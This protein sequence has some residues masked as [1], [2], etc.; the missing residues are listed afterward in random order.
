[1][2]DEYYQLHQKRTGAKPTITAATGKAFKELLKVHGREIVLKKLKAF[3]ASR[4]WFAE[5]PDAMSFRR[6][7]DKIAIK[8]TARANVKKCSHCGDETDTTSTF[9][10]ICGAPYDD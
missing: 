5:T 10:E 7:F 8:N 4:D 2:I 9:C 6:H 3:Y 1:M